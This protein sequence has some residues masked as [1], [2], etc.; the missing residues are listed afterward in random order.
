MELGEANTV[1]TTTSLP[2]HPSWPLQV[3]SHCRTS[4]VNFKLLLLQ[5]EYKHKIQSKQFEVLNALIHYSAVSESGGG[6]LVPGWAVV[7]VALAV[8]LNVGV[9]VW[10]VA[11]RGDRRGQHLKIA[12][13]DH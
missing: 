4:H 7:L 2:L 11:R 8:A 1:T 10:L 6:L 3:I 9:V 12:T 13:A 5:A